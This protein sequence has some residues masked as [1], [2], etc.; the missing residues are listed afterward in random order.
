M[1]IEMFSKQLIV[2]QVCGLIL[3]HLA[4]EDSVAASKAYNTFGGYCDPDLSIAMHALLN[5]YEEEDP[6]EAKAVLNKPCIKDLDIEFT[7][8]LKK[9]KLPDSGGLQAAAADFG[10]K[11]AAAM[12]LTSGSSRVK[13]CFPVKDED[14]DLC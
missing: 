9:I 4:R 1:T 14:E 8:M 13:E 11:R 12:N 3:V 2:S 6:E 5:A 10:A 7:R